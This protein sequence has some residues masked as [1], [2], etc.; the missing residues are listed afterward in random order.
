MNLRNFS[1]ITSHGISSYCFINLS[2]GFNMKNNV[3]PFLSILGLSCS[4]WGE[5][6]LSYHYGSITTDNAYVMQIQNINEIVGG[7]SPYHELR[8]GISSVDINN[9]S[10]ADIFLYG[11]FAP[12]KNSERG[13]GFGGTFAAAPIE[14]LPK[15]TL[16]FG[17]KAGIGWQPVKGDIKTISTNINKL[18]YVTTSNLSG[19]YTPTKMIYEEDTLV[20]NLSLVSG[21]GYD[22]SKNL[23]V[24]TEFGY[25]GAY[26][27]F[28]YRNEGSSISNSCTAR[29][30][31]FYTNIGLA[32]RF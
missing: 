10:K 20:F 15:M 19:F 32:Y 13:G 4:A 18:S 31:Q 26:Y 28:S 14:S 5:S 3:L 30:G 29:Q 25:T 22:I 9:A 2:K 8:Y 16:K 21:L 6:A 23:K 24:E 11:Y 12:D 27:Q 7:N 17:G 1:Q